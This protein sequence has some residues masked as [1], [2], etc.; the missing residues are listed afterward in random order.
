MGTKLKVSPTRS[1]HGPCVMRLHTITGLQKLLLRTSESR[2]LSPWL[3]SLVQSTSRTCSFPHPDP[4]VQ[5]PW[6]RPV[7]RRPI[8]CM[9][10]KKRFSCPRRCRRGSMHCHAVG[11]QTGTSS[12]AFTLEK[13]IRTFSTP[14]S[15]DLSTA[16]PLPDP[17]CMSSLDHARKGSFHATRAHVRI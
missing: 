5:L 4:A 17:T 2:A 1:T 13:N 3:Q 6:P 8:R 9:R 16:S 15:A 11:I 7:T 14:A 12:C 10:S